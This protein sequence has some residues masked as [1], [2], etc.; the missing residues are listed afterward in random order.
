MDA[1][2]STVG[3]LRK[4][5]SALESERKEREEAPEKENTQLKES[6]TALEAEKVAL[7]NRLEEGIL[8]LEE[9]RSRVRELES[10][11]RA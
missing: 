5:L 2:E 6:M 9:S 3:E 11:R 10:D 4:S 8:A 1:L 7:R